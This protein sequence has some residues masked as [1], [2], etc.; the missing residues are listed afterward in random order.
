MFK[1]VTRLLHINT[2]I[3]T[4]NDIISHLT[5]KHIIHRPKNINSS[6]TFK[7][8]LI[9]DINKNQYKNEQFMYNG[10]VITAVINIRQHHTKPKILLLLYFLYTGIVFLSKF[11]ILLLLQIIFF[12]NV[13][14]C[15]NN[16]FDS[17]EQNCVHQW[18]DYFSIYLKVYDFVQHELLY[19]YVQIVIVMLI[20]QFGLHLQQI[21]KI[22]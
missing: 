2:V 9:K 16:I 18:L 22:I 19:G 11:Y 12:T 20:K 17:P 1:T 14:C 7:F 5:Q 8:K 4:S 6:F 13:C 3:F 10:D 21:N 15:L